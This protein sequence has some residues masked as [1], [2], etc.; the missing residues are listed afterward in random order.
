MGQGQKAIRGRP[1]RRPLRAGYILRGPRLR[2]PNALFSA[3][4]TVMG[5]YFSLCG[6]GETLAPKYTLDMVRA[7][8]ENGHHVNVTTNGTLT[9]R[10]RELEGWDAELLRSLHFAFSF[11]YLELL[12][13]KKLDVFFDNIRYVKSLGCSFVLQLNLC[14]EYLPYLDEIKRVSMEN[15]G[16]W[17][18][19]AATRKE[20]ALDSKV[21]FE[22]ALSDEEYIAKGREFDSPLFEFTV[23]NFNVKRREFCYAGAWAFQLNLLTGELRPCYHSHRSQNIYEDVDAPIRKMSVGCSC[24]SLFCMNSSHFMS[25]GVIPDIE[26]PSYADLRDRPEAGWYTS[27]MRAFLGGK[28]GESNVELPACER[29]A[30]TAQG[31]ADNAY[32]KARSL[33][34]KVLTSV[35]L[36][37]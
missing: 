35:G 21:L 16:A 20:V 22:T 4:S 3:I 34:G 26:T 32:G 27:E 7:L 25:L 31:R 24:G 6:A 18:Q 11:H 37:K 15:V 30:A 10:F 23:K 5:C 28:L 14:D 1:D 17:P 29:M 9:K 33:G 8:L 12:R 13:L 36:K 2:T 19:I